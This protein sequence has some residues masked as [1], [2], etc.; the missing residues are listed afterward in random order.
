ML[1]F[2]I[3]PVHLYILN[4]FAYNN[5]CPVF[6]RVRSN[7]TFIF[8]YAKP[9]NHAIC[10]RTNMHSKTPYYFLDVISE[11][12]R[13]SYFTQNYD[14]QKIRA[15]NENIENSTWEMSFYAKAKIYL[16]ESLDE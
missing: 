7:T 6:V 4:L 8:C 15:H 16:F 13:K 11:D 10:G 14:Q 1:P 9:L 2:S 5:N 3:A 12:Y